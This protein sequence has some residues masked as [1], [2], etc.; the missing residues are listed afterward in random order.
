M[1]GVANVWDSSGIQ[2]ERMTYSGNEMVYFIM[3]RDKM[4]EDEALDYVQNVIE[5]EDYGIDAP[6]IVWEISFTSEQ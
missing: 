1:I 2:V 3:D 4:T 6:I 5:S